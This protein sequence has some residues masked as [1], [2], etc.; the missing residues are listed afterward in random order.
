M[1]SGFITKDNIFI[2]VPYYEIGLFAENV[3]KNYMEENEANKMQF[4]LFARD[5]HYFKPY[6]DLLLFQ[7]GY[8]MVNPLLQENATWYVEDNV[9]YLSKPYK[10][11]EY[12]YLPIRDD[13]LQIQYIAPEHLQN[14]IVD[15]RGIAYHF[16]RGMGLYHEE[17]YELVLNQ[18]L[19]YDKVLYEAYKSY[20]D[21]GKNIAA[22]CRNMLGFY[23][24][25]VEEDRSGYIV[26]CSDFYNSYM[27]NICKRVKE[28]YPKIKILGDKIHTEESLK[29]A[30]QYIEKAGEMSENRRI[31]L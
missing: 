19:I 20:T 13:A 26:Y 29:M 24:I 3:C 2:P 30:T 10:P 21:K 11:K 28:L 14:C 8:Q 18:Y 12:R 22:F 6:L 31:R 16:S 4:E 9:L 23:H 5:Y 7:L 27:D 15:F 25:A 1:K 17:I